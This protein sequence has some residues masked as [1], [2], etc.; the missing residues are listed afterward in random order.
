MLSV[1]N[2]FFISKTEIILDP[3]IKIKSY[4]NKSKSLVFI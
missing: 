1:I 2:I 3:Y 4:I